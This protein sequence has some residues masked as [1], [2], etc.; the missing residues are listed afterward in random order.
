MG[1]QRVDGDLDGGFRHRLEHGGNWSPPY[2]PN[3]TDNVVI[4]SATNQ[5]ILS[6]ATT[7]NNLTIGNTGTN[8]GTLT[9][10]GYSLSINGTFG[11]TGVLYRTGAA[12]ESVSNARGIF[13][14][15]SP[16]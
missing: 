14:P 12:T 6:A 8:L 5:P 16:S 13:S 7:T 9:T 11:S 10:S 15:V 4:A 1:V 3:A 2:V